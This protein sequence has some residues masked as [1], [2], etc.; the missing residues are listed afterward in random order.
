MCIPHLRWKCSNISKP[1]CSVVR[2]SFSRVLQQLLTLP[3]IK[4]EPWNRS[5]RRCRFSES[6]SSF[7]DSFVILYYY[8]RLTG[9]TCRLR[10]RGVS[11]VRALTPSYSRVPS[12]GGPSCRCSTRTPASYTSR[13]YSHPSVS[14]VSLLP[15][16]PS[17]LYNR[18]LHRQCDVEDSST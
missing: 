12:M 1:L 9:F 16:G 8:S 15:A 6:S 18:S 14:R 4:V 3:S 7:S 11:T 5:S 2:Q 17:K 10:P 13:S